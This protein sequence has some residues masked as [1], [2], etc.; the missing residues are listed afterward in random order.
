METYLPMG[1]F[2]M[3]T[4]V[5]KVNARYPKKKIEFA[6]EYS[7]PWRFWCPHLVLVAIWFLREID[8]GE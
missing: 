4:E 6:H 8:Y 1:N 2:T 3:R 5:G 7:C